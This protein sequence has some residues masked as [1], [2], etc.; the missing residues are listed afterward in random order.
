MAIVAS[1]GI[2]TGAGECPAG[3]VGEVGRKNGFGVTRGAG[4]GG[5]GDL[6]LDVELVGGGVGD[7]APRGRE[8]GGGRGGRRGGDFGGGR[9]GLGD[10]DRQGAGGV[11]GDAIGGGAGEGVGAGGGRGEEEIA[12]LEIVEGGGD[13]GGE[14]VGDGGRAGSG[15]GIFHVISHVA[16]GRRGRGGEG[17]GDVGRAVRTRPAHENVV[18]DRGVRALRVRPDVVVIAVVAV[19]VPSVVVPLTAGLVL[20]VVPAF[21]EARVAVL[22][23]IGGVVAHLVLVGDAVDERLGEGAAVGAV[24]GILVVVGGRDPA[25]VRRQRRR[26]AGPQTTAD[27]VGFLLPQLVQHRL[28]EEAGDGVF[29][30]GFFG[31]VAVILQTIFRSGRLGFGELRRQGLAALGRR[32]VLEHPRRVAGVQHHHDFHTRRERGQVRRHHLRRVVGI[33]GADVILHPVRV[34][35]VM[36]VDFPAVGRE[37]IVVISAVRGMVV[38]EMVA[39]FR[40][41]RGIRNGL[42]DLGPRRPAVGQERNVRRR[43]LAAGRDEVRHVAGVGHG[44]FQRV[45]AV[46]GLVVVDADADGIVGCG[47][48][49]GTKEDGSGKNGRRSEGEETTECCHGVPPGKRWG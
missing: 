12:V 9:R 6:L 49:A 19:I 30:G 10:G 17:G 34:Q 41:G 13:G 5:G 27:L 24:P 33:V 47:G 18:Q 28:H 11:G 35:V 1:T 21:V 48:G 32:V 43:P 22:V 7:G 26:G 15:E 16:A 20:G 39:A 46:G 45:A 8:G 25:D 31:G 4:G 36:Q 14:G 3:G 40:L 44:A 42:A 2:G 37:V 38:Q 23:A 29:R